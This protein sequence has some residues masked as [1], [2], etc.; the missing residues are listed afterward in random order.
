MTVVAS[1]LYRDGTCAEEVPLGRQAIEHKEGEF[2]WI[3]L[4]DPTADKMCSGVTAAAGA[5]QAYFQDAP[6]GH[7]VS[8]NTWTHGRS[9]RQIE[10]SGIALRG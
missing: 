4:V 5:D 9:R 7:T 2:S 10:P 3:G 8:A 6:P 1:Y